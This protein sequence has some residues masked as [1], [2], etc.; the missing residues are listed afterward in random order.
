MTTETIGR[1]LRGIPWPDIRWWVA[2]ATFSLAL[3]MMLMIRENPAL[4]A[5]AP[6]AQLSGG[7]IALMGMVVQYLFGGAKTSASTGAAP[8]VVETTTTTEV[9]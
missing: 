9:R 5:V 4:L 8:P 2:C 3:I 6:F 7:I 1:V